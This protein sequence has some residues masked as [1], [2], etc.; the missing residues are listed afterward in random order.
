MRCIIGNMS[1]HS[2]WATIKRAKAVNDQARGKV[3]SRL[4]RNITI[5]VKEGGGTSPDSNFRLR[6]AIDAARAANMPKENIERAI[7]KGGGEADALFEVV[8]EGFGPGGVGVIV[9]TTTDNKN[10]TAQEV[11]NLLERA[12]GSLGGPNSVA[13]NFE[14]KGYMHLPGVSSSNDEVVLKLIDAGV[15]DYE[16]GEEGMDIYTNPTELYSVRQALEATGITITESSLIKKPVNFV[17]ID[18][19]VHKQLEDLLSK[20]DDLDAV[21]NVFVNAR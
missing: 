7:S 5:A 2:K 12:G 14:T 16:D 15:T 11:K 17:D 19:K 10:R 21:D 18:E 6:I 13:F 4:G 1:G 20:L 9:E 8:Y 3:F